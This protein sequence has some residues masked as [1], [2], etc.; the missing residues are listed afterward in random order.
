MVLMVNELFKSINKVNILKDISFSINENEILGLIGPNGSGKSTIMKCIA[1][2]YH[3]TSGEITINGYDI[4]KDRVNALSNMGVSIEYPALY[5]NLTGKDHFK[6]VAKWKK[7]DKSRIKEMEDFSGLNSELKKEVRHYSMGMKQRLILSLAM[8]T[9]PKLLILDEPTNGLDP[10]AII[11]LRKK[12]LDIRNDGTSILL[13]SHQLSEVDKL[14]DRIIFIKERAFLLP[15]NC[16]DFK[17]LRVVR[18]GLYLGDCLKKRFE[19]SQALA[20]ALKPEEYKRS[21]SFKAEDICVEKYLRGETVDIEDAG[22]NGWTLFC[23]DEFPLGW[24]KCNRGRLKNKYNPNW[25]KL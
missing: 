3:P 6:M 12:L 9:K 7:L 1:G 17:G 5:P 16:P 13:S 8:M 20:M 15:E 4:D 14:V 2:L 23:V 21:V 10:Q 19:P 25:R 24:G 18:S 11:D 22:L